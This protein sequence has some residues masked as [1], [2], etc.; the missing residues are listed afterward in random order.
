M[1]RWRKRKAELGLYFSFLCCICCMYNYDYDLQ[2]VI[3]YHYGI[4]AAV[5][6]QLTIS[7]FQ[8]T[9]GW[10]FFGNT[11]QSNRFWHEGI[12]QQEHSSRGPHS[13]LGRKTCLRSRD[14]R[15]RVP[16]AMD[17]ILIAYWKSHI[18]TVACFE[19]ADEQTFLIWKWKIQTMCIMC[20][21]NSSLINSCQLLYIRLGFRQIVTMTFQ[22]QLNRNMPAILTDET[23]PIIGPTVRMRYK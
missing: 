7:I 19:C 5:Q 3:I 17:I 8:M 23:R 16:S 1:A 4:A 2:H 22:M 15:S 6:L 12:H 20:T 21:Q 13:N 9:C 10:K 18:V 11:F 14:H